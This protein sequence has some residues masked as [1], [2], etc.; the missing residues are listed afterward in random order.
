MANNDIHSYLELSQQDFIQLLAEISART[1]PPPGRRQVPF[2]AVETLL[3][4]GLFY[5]VDPHHYGGANIAQVPAVVKTLS[6][7][8]R[9]TP[10]SITSKMLNLDGSRLHSARDEPNLFANLAAQPNLYNTLYNDIITAARK[11]SIPDEIL[12]DFLHTQSSNLNAVEFLA[13][14]ELPT[15]NSVLLVDAKQELEELDQVFALGDMLTEKLVEQKIRLAQHRF[16]LAVLENCG[17]TCVFCGF[18]PHS[19]PLQS[20]LLR[21]S[22]IKPWSASTPTERID[23]RNG[24]TACPMH[25]AAF[26]QGYLSVNGGFRIHLAQI[27]QESLTHDQRVRLY[28]RDALNEILFLPPTAKRP[29]E[30]YLT[31][32][33][34]HIFK[35]NIH[36]SN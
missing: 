13:Q 26:D 28:F 1:F 35:G 9:R 4:Y 12:P 34:E 24:L 36:T 22:H 18:A 16:A 21:A 8:F 25:D 17:R 29:A 2:N 7:F 6:T 19:L 33:R 20:G 32:H 3:C 27:L 5:I 14:D 31:Y 11:L 15:S 10:G 23:V 30:R